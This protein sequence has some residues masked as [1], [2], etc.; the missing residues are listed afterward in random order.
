MTNPYISP[1]FR[2][3]LWLWR[4]VLVLGMPAI[5]GYL[6]RRSRRDP[7][8]FRHLRERFG[9]HRRRSRRHIW[10]HAVSLGELRSAEPLIRS[11]LDDGYA[12]V[13]T[14]FTP[15]GRRAAYA[16]FQREIASGQLA[17]VWVPF[18]LSLTFRGFFKAFRPQVGLVMEVEMWPGMIAAC[19][20]QRIPLVLCNGQ[21]P[22]RSF[23][24]DT[25]RFLSRRD[26]VSG[27]AGVMVKDTVQANRFTDLGQECV[28][29]TGEMRFEIQLK[30]NQVE[31]A[32]SHRALLAKRPTV[33]FASVV[34]GEDGAFISSIKAS[35][36]RAVYVPRAP[37]RFDETYALLSEAGLRVIRRSAVLGPNLETSDDLTGE[38]DVML[39]DSLGEMAY[40]LGLC[41][42][43]VIGGGFVPQGSHNIIEALILRKP[44]IVGP[45]IWTIEFPAQAA[46]SAGVV[47]QCH[48]EDLHMMLS[49]VPPTDPIKDFLAD[50]MGSVAKTRAAL[51][52]FGIDL[53]PL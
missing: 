20:A 48:A 41:D 1:K 47:R 13:T 18:D 38:W 2:A 27:F 21:Y 31:A 11:F 50:Q 10:I 29:V 37:E 19:A 24:R 14:H 5:L 53:E 32:A 9:F 44:V 36:V 40:Y 28:A 39:G 46:L 30:T 51:A 7:D 12:I 17:A 43:T 26:L 42:Q 52:S 4:T 23:E 6:W 33:T 45:Y 3:F 22:T 25:K 15:A 35:G 34:A 49:E 16:M 8:Y